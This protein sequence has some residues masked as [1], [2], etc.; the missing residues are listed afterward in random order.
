MK[1]LEKLRNG[2]IRSNHKIERREMLRIGKT[3]GTDM[4]ERREMLRI[5]K[6]GSTH[7]TEKHVKSNKRQESQTKWQNNWKGV[8]LD[9]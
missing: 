5:G 7:M 3:G 1:G 4:T 6:I 2:K 8:Q 9:K